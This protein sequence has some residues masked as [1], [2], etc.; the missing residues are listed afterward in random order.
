MALHT[1][2]DTAKPYQYRISMAGKND[3]VAVP[4][5]VMRNVAVLMKWKGWNQS[6]LDRKSGVSQRHIS[7]LLR[8]HADCTTEVAEKLAAAFGVP[9]WLLMVDDITE[10]LLTNTDLQIVV[11]TY[12]KRPNGRKLI[13]GA[14]DMVRSTP[15][16]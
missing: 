9:S 3:S 13:L 6:E 2:K 15:K 16:T 5:R 14:V 10:E 8:G 1:R 12:V 4:T 7:D 11:D